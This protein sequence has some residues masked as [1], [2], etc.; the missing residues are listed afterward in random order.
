MAA[1]SVTSASTETDQ[2]A[3]REKLIFTG[4][5]YPAIGIP[6]LILG[7]W[8]GFG[9]AFQSGA[10]SAFM[11]GAIIAAL[12]ECA[13]ENWKDGFAHAKAM[14]KAKGKDRGM[15]FFAVIL[16]TAFFLANMYFAVADKTALHPSVDWVQV[17]VFIVAAAFLPQARF[18]FTG[19]KFPTIGELAKS[20]WDFGYKIGSGGKAE[21]AHEAAPVPEVQADAPVP[22][23]PTS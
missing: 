4:W 18:A 13:F 16:A 15:A 11:C 6:F 2:A 7:W 23:A 8:G 21:R 10:A 3:N 19:T 9:A 20:G 12:G 17:T 22:P 14:I 1:T 5:I